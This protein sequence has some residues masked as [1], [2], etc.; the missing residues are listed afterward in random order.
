MFTWFKSAIPFLKPEPYLCWWGV[1]RIDPPKVFLG[2]SS[3]KGHGCNIAFTG[4]C[5][6]LSSRQEETRHV[7]ESRAQVIVALAFHAA[8]LIMTMMSLGLVAL[9]YLGFS[10]AVGGFSIEATPFNKL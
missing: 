8:L 7:F 9:S 6:Y 2:S 3:S 5:L 10:T 4:V 1:G